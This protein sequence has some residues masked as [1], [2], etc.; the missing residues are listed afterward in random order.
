MN[1]VRFLT[2]VL[3]I[4]LISCERDNY[5]TKSEINFGDYSNMI[6]TYYDTILVGGYHNSQNLD[7]DI[8][9]DNIYN[10][11]LIS[12]VWGS[13]GLGQN[14]CSKIWTLN[15]NTLMNGYLKNDTSFLNRSTRILSGPNNTTEIYEY[16]RYS[17]HQ[18]EESDS[19]LNIYYDV[20]RLSQKTE[21]IL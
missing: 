8:N 12:E 7:I 1:T 3:L 13:P 5:L 14:P 19:I 6:D 18:I 2:I 16:Y 10:I 11:R 4:F 15:D 20:F 9:N 17:C 21:T